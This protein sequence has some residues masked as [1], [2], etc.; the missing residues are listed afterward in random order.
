MLSV[1]RHPGVP[2]AARAASPQ[3]HGW[4]WTL[5]YE[6]QDERELL[7]FLNSVTSGSDPLFVGVQDQSRVFFNNLRL[8]WLADRPIGVRAFQLETGVATESAVQQVQIDDL[9]HNRVNW[10]VLDQDQTAGDVAFWKRGYRGA[11]DFDDYVAAHYT[12]VARFG[13]FSVM[14]N[15]STAPVRG[16]ARRNAPAGLSLVRSIR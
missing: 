10:I 6:D 2:D 12:E 9:K 15:V 14:R 8:Y 11:T 4:V 13:R 7:G 1:L 16:H 5:V 3:E